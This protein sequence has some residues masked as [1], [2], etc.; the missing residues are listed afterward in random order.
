MLKRLPI[1][2]VGAGFAP[3]LFEWSF[4]GV[5]Y[6]TSSIIQVG[7]DQIMAAVNNHPLIS[8]FGWMDM[9]AIIL[10]DLAF[11][12]QMYPL[13][14]DIASRYFKLLSLG[15]LS[16]LAVSCWVFDEH[17]G[18]FDTWLDSIKRIMFMFLY[19]AIFLTIMG[20]LIV[21]IGGTITFKGLVIRLLIIIGCVQTMLNPP[22]MI[23]RYVERGDSLYDLI[24][25]LKETVTLEKIKDQKEVKFIK[26]QATSDKA[27]KKYLDG[28]VAWHMFKN[29]FKK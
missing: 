8:G 19:W 24:K 28:Y 20:V 27:K 12:R 9:I 11:V 6:I 21:G 18:W 10:F 15:A 4:K 25:D 5:D 7:K 26:K 23:K 1:A 14:M 13:F 3:K 16:P 2:V 29:W 17:R 22:S